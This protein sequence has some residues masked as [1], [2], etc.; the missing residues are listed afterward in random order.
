MPGCKILEWLVK[1]RGAFKGGH[2]V[3]LPD[4]MDPGPDRLRNLYLGQMSEESN[5]NKRRYFDNAATSFPKPPEV[6][7]AM[8]DYARHLGASPGRGAYWEVTAT[9][10]IVRRCRVRLCTR[11]CI[12]EYP[13]YAP[14]PKSW[15]IRCTAS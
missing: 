5:S 1:V 7:D 13:R 4:E 14:S 9:S 11:R 15:S 10:D 3:K 2:E 8:A 12:P 6:T